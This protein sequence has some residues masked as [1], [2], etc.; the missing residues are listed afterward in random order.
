MCTKTRHG[1]YFPLEPVHAD[2][3][4]CLVQYGNFFLVCGVGAGLD[5]IRVDTM[6]CER[7]VTVGSTSI[8]HSYNSYD[9]QHLRPSDFRR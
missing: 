9:Q 3:N 2:V 8:C 6:I 7:S 5:I 4:E 1:I